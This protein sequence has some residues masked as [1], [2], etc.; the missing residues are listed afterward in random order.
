MVSIAMRRTL[1]ALLLVGCGGQPDIA[2]LY[3]ATSDDINAMGC[4]P[5]SPSGALPIFLI[6]PFDYLLGKAYKYEF[7]TAP[8]RA[9]CLDLGLLSIGFTDEIDGGWESDA[10]TAT[11]QATGCAI[12]RT[13]GTATMSDDHTIV[14][15]ER[16]Y[17]GSTTSAPNGCTL[18]YARAHAQS[19]ACVTRDLTVGTRINESAP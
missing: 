3:R 5:L 8:Q 19:L 13:L 6:E 12:E 11:P 2:G 17:R 18:D 7:C 9:T 16:T 14:I 4:Q 1:P 15:D 10:F